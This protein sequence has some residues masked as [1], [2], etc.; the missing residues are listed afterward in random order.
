VV[1]LEHHSREETAR[2]LLNFQHLLLE[3]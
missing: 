1:V 2:S 3:T